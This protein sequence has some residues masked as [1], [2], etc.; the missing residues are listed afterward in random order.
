[1]FCEPLDGLRA[2]CERHPVLG[3]LATRLANQ[4]TPLFVVGGPVRDTL[5]GR[6]TA[7]L[8]VAT[9]ATPE[10]IADAADGLGTVNLVGAAYGVVKIA[11]SGEEV[12]VATF[13]SDRY[14]PG[15]RRP[16]VSTTTDITEDLSRRD[17][18]INAMAVP[19]AGDLDLIDPFGGRAH[20]SHS[21]LTTPQTAAISFRDDPL[22]I[23]RAWR[24][25]ATLRLTLDDALLAAAAKARQAL[26]VVSRERKLA[27]LDKVLAHPDADVL[28]HAVALM[29]R[30]H[31]LG[32]VLPGA[33]AALQPPPLPDRP[34]RLVW[35]ASTISPQLPAELGM[36]VSDQK[37]V[38][39][40]LT[41]AAQVADA[42]AVAA[43]AA[44]R[45]HPDR[46]LDAAAPLLAS[47]PAAAL[48]A[49]RA[50]AD[51]WRA[52]LPIDGADLLAAAG[53]TAG[54]WVGE[55]LRTAEQDWLAAAPHTDVPERFRAVVL[56][57][58]VNAA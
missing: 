15:S 44:V 8:D 3:P 58:A 43:R 47:E 51:R 12:D 53:R 6:P 10:K 5:L 32:D 2:R 36:P 39:Q 26:D 25:A 14:T 56:E 1:M 23:H 22:R 21:V 52:P 17:F 55:L 19:L 35:L 30:L 33:P 45:A 24:F 41:V 9:A 18:T 50:A 57:R 48:Q 11:S 16:V 54:P 29:R 42:D 37:L 28:P 7:D 40:A 4:G 13:R 34:S 46:V 20:L 49:A 31:V 27:E 38:R